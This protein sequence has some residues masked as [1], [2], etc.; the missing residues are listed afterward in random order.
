M[1]KR[2]FTLV[3]LLAVII[4]LGVVFA[5]AIPNVLNMIERT[6]I[7]AIIRSEEML[8]IAARR[9]LASNSHLLPVNAGSTIEITLDTLKNNRLIDSIRNPRNNQECNG[10]VLITRLPNNQ[11][12]YSPQ[13]NCIDNTRG[14]ILSDGLIAYYKFDDFQEPTQNL[15][16]PNNPF[17]ANGTT[18]WAISNAVGGSFQVVNDSDFITGRAL[19]VVVATSGDQWQH[20]ST[21]IYPAD[22]VGRTF[23]VSVSKKTENV[24]GNTRLGL[25][26]RDVNGAWIWSNNVLISTSAST[27]TN[28]TRLSATA[29]A[30]V[31]ARH[32]TIILAGPNNGTGNYTF[33]DI[34]IEEKPYSTPFVATSRSGLVYDHS[35][36]NHN[37]NL[38]VQNTP[39]WTENS[40]VGRGAYQFGLGAHNFILS[41]MSAINQ[42]LT[43][44]AWIRPTQYPVER[45]TIIQGVVSPGYYLSLNN[46]GS[47]NSYWYNT[48]PEG[49][50]TTAAGVVLLNVWSHV[51]TNWDG[52]NNRLYVNGNL[53]ATIPTTGLGV[54]S[55]T[56]N[57]GAEFPGRQFF[58]FI[59][60][61]R[62]YNRALS[63]S[64]VRNIYDIENNRGR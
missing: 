42:R 1:N 56:I 5:I 38:T 10:Y 26:W 44:C 21:P 41:N 19:R 7:D 33:G 20:Y 28:L 14:S 46:N 48:T 57:I 11:F 8:T 9:H 3:E 51:C 52:T 58:G 45:S 40:K 2:A 53:L 31:G 6:R 29:T 47:L 32:V 18:G 50:H 64:E 37:A 39:R 36:N 17:F 23:T 16:D 22:I 59:D 55:S 13:L 30:P 27:I 35:G 34:Q 62:I 24:I 54:A 43:L 25:Y 60:D 61:V 63:I 4:I 49:Y 15:A 12:E